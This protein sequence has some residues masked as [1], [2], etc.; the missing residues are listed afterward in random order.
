MDGCG[1]DAPLERRVEELLEGLSSL[2]LEP[3]QV[4]DAA[5]LSLRFALAFAERLGLEGEDEPGE[6]EDG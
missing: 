5:A 4:A 1:D 6:P 2:G 3:A